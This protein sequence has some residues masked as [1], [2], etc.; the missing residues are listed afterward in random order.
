M[1]DLL[2]LSKNL[3]NFSTSSYVNSKTCVKIYLNWIK[4]IVPKENKI[5]IRYIQYTIIEENYYLFINLYQCLIYHDLQRLFI[6]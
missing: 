5:I 3:I 6:D 2:S 4:L 1:A